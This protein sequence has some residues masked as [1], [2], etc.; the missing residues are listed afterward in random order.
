MNGSAALARL[1][2]IPGCVDQT[3]IFQD[4]CHARPFDAGNRVDMSG[5]I[6][7]DRMSTSRN[8]RNRDTSG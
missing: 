2:R 4:L 6:K 7:L 3:R 5:F 8:S 1:V